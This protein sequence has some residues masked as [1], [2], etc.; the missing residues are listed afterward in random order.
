MPAQAQ[1]DNSGPVIP[2]DFPFANSVPVTTLLGT[3]KL[4][5]PWFH[6]MGP[7]RACCYLDQC[8]SLPSHTWHPSCLWTPF[9]LRTVLIW[10]LKFWAETVLQIQVPR[11]SWEPRHRQPEFLLSWLM[12]SY[13]PF[14]WFF[15]LKPDLCSAV[16]KIEDA[17]MKVHLPR[18]FRLC[19]GTLCASI[20]L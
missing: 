15:M 1:T 20:H 4:G 13:S 14:L 5:F 18:P 2:K 10:A 7:K 8:L 12:G 9:C 6:I 16:L 17:F 11:A 3:L 19:M